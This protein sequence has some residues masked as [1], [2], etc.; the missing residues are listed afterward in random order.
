VFGLQCNM[1]SRP[2]SPAI[3]E[4]NQLKLRKNQVHKLKMLALRLQCNMQSR[5]HSPA[6]QEANQLKLRKNQVHTNKNA[7]AWIT[8]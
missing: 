4:A 2:H 1:Q 5:P 7:R 8:V 6:I 3:Q